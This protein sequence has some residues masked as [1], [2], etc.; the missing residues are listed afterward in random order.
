[1]TSEPHRLQYLDAMGL[2]AWMSKYQLPNALPSEVCDWPEPLT[3]KPVGKGAEPEL[4]PRER[5]QALLASD[6]SPVPVP[7]PDTAPHRDVPSPRATPGQQARAL[8]E[9]LSPDSADAR[10]PV[11]ARGDAAS[12]LPLDQRAPQAERQSPEGQAHWELHLQTGCVAGRWLVIVPAQQAL[13]DA[14]IRLL[15]NL[16]AAA[17]IA[18]EQPPTLEGYRWP[19]FQGGS[20]Q[21]LSHDPCQDARDGLSAF[22]RGR[23]RLGWHPRQVLVFGMDD[24]LRQLLDIESGHSATLDLPVWLGPELEALSTRAE[25]KRALWPRLADWQAARHD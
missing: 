6:D 21:A 24:T 9:G 7:S 4:A 10:Q 23:Q 12:V 3:D 18:T 19:P 15:S 20:L 17:G 16:F 13:P 22:V 8:L 5:F 2:T 25:Q 11:Q 1:M 14:L